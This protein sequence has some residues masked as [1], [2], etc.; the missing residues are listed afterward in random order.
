MTLDGSISKPAAGIGLFVLFIVGGNIF[1]RR[2]NPQPPRE[3]YLRRPNDVA[4]VAFW[5]LFSSDKWTDEGI[6]FHKR[7][8][9]FIPIALAAFAVLWFLADLAW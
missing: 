2:W 9:L 8:L 5:N 7:R 3:R 6:R 1:E 4:L